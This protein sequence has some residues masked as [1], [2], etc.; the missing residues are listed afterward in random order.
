MII[1]AAN[2]FASSPL[3]NRRDR[4]MPD[5]V[6]CYKRRGSRRIS[7]SEQDRPTEVRA[8]SPATNQVA[9][10]GQLESLNTICLSILIPN[11]CAQDFNHLVW[12]YYLF[13]V[14]E[15]VF[16]HPRLL[17]V[18]SQ[19]LWIS[20]YWILIYFDTIVTALLTSP[21]SPLD[22]LGSNLEVTLPSKAFI[23]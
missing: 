13:S 16:R 23:V 9:P 20:V 22:S 8:H 4:I 12:C 11:E 7:C 14:A 5:L 10:M 3:V 19:S 6:D 17:P 1:F 21:K 2:P 15:G 18:G